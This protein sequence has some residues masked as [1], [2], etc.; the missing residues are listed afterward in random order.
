MIRYTLADLLPQ[1]PV[2]CDL[3]D[4]AQLLKIEAASTPAAMTVCAVLGDDGLCSVK[5]S[6][7]VLRLYPGGEC[8]DA[9]ERPERRGYSAAEDRLRERLTKRRIEARPASRSAEIIIHE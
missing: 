4:R 3:L 6:R 8:I 9:G 5:A 1:Q 7:I 2:G